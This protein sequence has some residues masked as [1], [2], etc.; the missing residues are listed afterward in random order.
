MK[1]NI[2]SLLPEELEE[3]LALIGE[4]KFRAKQIFKWLSM[5][6]A[7]FDEMTN[8]SKELRSKLN[9]GYY[10]T[11]PRIIRKQ[12]SKIDGTIKYLWGLYDGNTVESVLMRYKYGNT[13]CISSQVGCRMG[14]AFCA[15]TLGGLVRGLEPSEM[16]DQILFAQKDSG[17]KISD[18]KSVV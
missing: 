15:S 5:G 8:I 9:D 16:T 4:K 10:I 14:C 11:C 6:A 18:R 3:E 12:V 7:S 2:K 17:E 13:I 1:K